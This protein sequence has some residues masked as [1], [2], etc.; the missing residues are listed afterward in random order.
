M[1]VRVLDVG[2][3]MPV[4]GGSET[5]NKRL[6]Y[7]KNNPEVCFVYF[8]SPFGKL[9]PQMAPNP[10]CVALMLPPEIAVDLACTLRFKTFT[11]ACLEEPVSTCIGTSLCM[12]GFNP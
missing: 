12:G 1:C 7:F 5:E 2:A 10:G 11:L 8:F 9:M 3:E 4:C 6:L